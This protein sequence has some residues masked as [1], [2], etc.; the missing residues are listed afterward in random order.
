MSFNQASLGNLGLAGQAG[1]GFQ[2]G[3]RFQDGL[4]RYREAT[5]GM[6]EEE[7]KLFAPQLIQSLFPSGDDTLVRGILEDVQKKG[8]K[9]YQEEMLELADKY[10]TRKGVRQTAFN[11]FGSGMD[12]LMKGIGMSMNPY[13]TREGLQSYL[14]LTAAA[15]QA[16]SAGY[17]GLRTPMNIPAVQVGSGPTY[18]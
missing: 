1:F 2:T 5:K 11:L 8:T 12:N 7:K 3:D 6:S 10:Q 13:G 15:P 16:M 9:E 4:N 18:F 17:Q 14:A